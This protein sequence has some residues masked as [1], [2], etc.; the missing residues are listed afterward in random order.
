MM[1]QSAP[2]AYS[3][4]EAAFIAGVTPTRLDGWSKRGRGFLS[5]AGAGRGAGHPVRYGRQELLR[6]KVYLVLQESFG[7]RHF[8]PSPALSKALRAALTDA[9]VDDVLKDVER[10]LDGEAAALP[11]PRPINWASPQS[12]VLVVW[13]PVKYDNEMHGRRSRDLHAAV[14]SRDGLSRI[15]PARDVVVLVEISLLARA[16]VLRERIVLAHRRLVDA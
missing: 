12:R 13:A 15:D 2:G 6:A 14:V 4:S 10:E 9:A 7:E 11:S 5:P 3:R 16:I 8:R 1:H